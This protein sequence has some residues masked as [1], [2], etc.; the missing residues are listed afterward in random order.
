MLGWAPRSAPDPIRRDFA[1]RPRARITDPRRRPPR[2]TRSAKTM[3]SSATPFFTRGTANSP[4]SSGPNSPFLH[5]DDGRRP[6]TGK[7]MQSDNA[8]YSLSAQ[9][10][11]RSRVLQIRWSPGTREPDRTRQAL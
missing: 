9:N 5:F 8:L 7:P 3:A 4:E 2:H 10:P 11:N 1:L 6:A